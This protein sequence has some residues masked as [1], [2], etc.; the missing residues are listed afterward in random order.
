MLNAECQTAKANIMSK[1]DAKFYKAAMHQ[2]GCLACREDTD[3]K[4]EE[5]RHKL[6]S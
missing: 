5:L 1:D 4:L 3:R 6:L 2:R